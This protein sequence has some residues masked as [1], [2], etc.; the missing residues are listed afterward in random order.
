MPPDGKLSRGRDRRRLHQMGYRRAVG[1]SEPGRGRR[2]RPGRPIAHGRA[3]PEASRPA[4]SHAPGVLGSPGR[5]H[6]L[7][8]HPPIALLLMAAM[9]EMASIILQ[10]T[11]RTAVRA[12]ARCMRI[13]R[14]SRARPSAV[15]AMGLGWV[16]YLSSLSYAASWV[17]GMDAWGRRPRCSRQGE[18]GGLS[19]PRSARAR[20]GERRIWFIVTVALS[21]AATAHL[22]GSVYG[23]HYLQFSTPSKP[24]R[25]A[26]PTESCLWAGLCCSSPAAC[27]TRTARMRA[28][29]LPGVEGVALQ[30]MGAQVTRRLRARGRGAGAPRRQRRVG[31]WLTA[32]APGSRSSVEMRMMRGSCARLSEIV[33]QMAG[34]AQPDV[35]R[36]SPPWPA[37]TRMRTPCSSGGEGSWQKAERGDLADP[38][39]R[40]LAPSAAPPR[41]AAFRRLVEPLARLRIPGEPGHAPM[42]SG[43]QQGRRRPG[44]S[45]QGG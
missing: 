3:S 17:C 35:A 5:L 14:P 8:V 12:P 10:R 31:P 26:R 4:E 24:G 27:A 29:V 40:A 9:A 45:C 28:W 11:G 44:P 18:R 22:G 38:R 7:A 20:G 25:Y 19:R 32:A 39:P 43:E 13:S 34:V 33:R 1:Q 2:P 30:A 16:L 21:I 37:I 42:R 41:K 15:L 36:R 23:I 6:L